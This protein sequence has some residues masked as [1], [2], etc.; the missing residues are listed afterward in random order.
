MAQWR[1]AAVE[2]AKVKRAELEAMTDDDVR[3]AVAWILEDTPNQ[4]KNPKSEGYSGLI[5]QQRL[6]QKLRT[7]GRG[8]SL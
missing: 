6:F 1:S 8:G 2:L 4:Y 7:K 3:K 5:E